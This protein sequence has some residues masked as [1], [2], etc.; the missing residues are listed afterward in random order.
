MRSETNYVH[1]EVPQW[2]KQSGFIIKLKF[3]T[4][5]P[6]QTPGAIA[7]SRES[8]NN[9]RRVVKLVTVVTLMFAVSW[10]P[11]QL[12]L[13]LKSIR[14]YPVTILNISVQVRTEHL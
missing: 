6:P 2:S 7:V 9:K 5:F 3:K 4:N 14:L 8:V 1:K 13:L 11:I 12:I 10:L